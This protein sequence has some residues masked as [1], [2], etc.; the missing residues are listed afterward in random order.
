MYKAI[1]FDLD[2][3]LLD[4]LPDIKDAI[5]QALLEC[6]YEYSFTLK[7]STHLIGDGTDN[8][9]RRALKENSGDMD[10]FSE[11]KAHYMGY[12]KAWQNLHTKPFPGMVETLSELKKR[13][14]K[15]FVA[16]NK[17]DAL[18]NVI[19]PAH[20]GEGFFDRIYG[21][22][23]G[24]PVKPNPHQVLK[25]LNE[26]GF[27]KDEV[28]YVGD[29]V[30]DVNTAENAGLRCCLCL[31]GYGFYMEELLKRPSFLLHRP[32]ELADLI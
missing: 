24:D 21:I 7:E 22:K 20:F 10:A 5:N 26:N 11:L 16:T 30:T 32:E 8:L 17:P 23:D 25:I 19:V 1:I 28:L 29:S 2:G 13:G 6:G 18:A 4:T 9:I 14:I 27:A 31:W 12:Y 15:L 3:T